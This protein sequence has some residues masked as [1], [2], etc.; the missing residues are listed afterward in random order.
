[1]ETK[2][3]VFSFVFFFIILRWQDRPNIEPKLSKGQHQSDEPLK[4]DM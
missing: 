1:M 3:Q 4:V 2:Y